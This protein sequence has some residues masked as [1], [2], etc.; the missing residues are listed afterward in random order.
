MKKKNEL[1][2]FL[3]EWEEILSLQPFFQPKTT[4]T[5]VQSTTTNNQSVTTN[6]SNNTQSSTQTNVLQTNNNTFN[7][8][9]LRSFS[10]KDSINK[11]EEEIKLEE[12]RL[13]AL[14]KNENFS[15]DELI[16]CWNQYIKGLTEQQILK[17]TMMTCKPILEDNFKISIHVDN[18]VQKEQHS[19]YSQS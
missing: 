13:K 3:G 19:C 1:D 9:P 7:K 14:A 8:R 10:I 6:S 5:Q 15:Q 18:S 12:A 2:D 11:K 17:N 4:N 16:R